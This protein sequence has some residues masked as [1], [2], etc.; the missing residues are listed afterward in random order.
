M[1]GGGASPRLEFHG[2]TIHGSDALA[3]RC[4]S[5][6]AH[7]EVGVSSPIQYLPRKHVDRSLA[8]L[9]LAGP[10]DRAEIEARWGAAWPAVKSWQRLLDALLAAFPAATAA[11]LD[12]DVLTRWMQRRHAAR[13]LPQ[14]EFAASWRMTLMRPQPARCWRPAPAPP[15]A[16][17]LHF[18]A[19][20]HS[21]AEL[22]AALGVSAGELDWLSARYRGHSHYRIREIPRANGR[23]RRLEIPKQRLK[24]VQRLILQRLLP[25]DACAPQAHGFVPGRS[26]LSHARQHCARGCVLQMDLC[27]WFGGIH[28]PR[29]QSVFVDLGYPPT[30][31]EVLARLCTARLAPEDLLR[32]APA[33]RQAARSRHLPQG[34]PTSPALANLCARG[35]DRRLAAYAAKAGWRYSRYADD[36][37][38]SSEAGDPQPF[39]HALPTLERIIRDEGFLPNPRK[40]R[41][42]TQGRRQQLTGVVV[43]ARPNMARPE[44]DRLKAEVHAWCRGEPRSEPGE[45]REHALQSLRGRLAWLR[46]LHPARGERLLER[47]R[48]AGILPT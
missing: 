27:D 25:S 47:L 11:R 8:L 33:E 13:R 30:V 44:F 4:K 28:M 37:V 10:W 42:H 14:L 31:A 45:E 40:T 32:L 2:F 35:L 34:A 21:V 19:P 36:L 23:H 22:A 9:A 39:R 38:F 3:A 46:Q 5:V 6:A 20:L 16:P 7:A 29:V 15:P 18:V 1:H 43:N 17:R 26:A 48:G 24:Q 12:V 41:L